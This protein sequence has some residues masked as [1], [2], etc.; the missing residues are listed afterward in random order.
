[1]PVNQ[2]RLHGLRF[3]LHPDSVK[4][5]NRQPHQ[6]KDSSLIHDR[7][8]QTLM[9]GG[10]PLSLNFGMENHWRS[11]LF[12]LLIFCRGLRRRSSYW[13]DFASIEFARDGGLCQWGLEARRVYRYIVRTS[14]PQISL[15]EARRYHWL[16]QSTLHQSNAPHCGA[17]PSSTFQT[18]IR[19]GIWD[20]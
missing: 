11:R 17:G 9:L 16:S 6:M 1:M 12:A 15:Q 7:L 5:E 4:T 13:P 3:P 2:G 8:K 19:P 18:H 10:L 14:Y 20:F